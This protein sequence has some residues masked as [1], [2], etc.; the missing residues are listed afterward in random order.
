MP[1]KKC[2]L[3]GMSVLYHYKS[4]DGKSPHSLWKIT[5]KDAEG[6]TILCDFPLSGEEMRENEKLSHIESKLDDILEI[7][8]HESK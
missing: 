1:F 6:K 8:N 3:C 2:S 7:L 5:I 4:L